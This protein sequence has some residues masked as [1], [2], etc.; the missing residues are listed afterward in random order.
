VL[1]ALPV[2]VVVV[3]GRRLLLRGLAG[4]GMDGRRGG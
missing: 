3:L 2:V 1:A 4:W